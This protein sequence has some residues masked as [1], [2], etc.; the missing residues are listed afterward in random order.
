MVTAFHNNR[1]IF[2]A[3]KLGLAGLVTNLIG[4]YLLNDFKIYS[5][6]IFCFLSLLVLSPTA[7][8]ICSIITL[9][10]SSFFDSSSFDSIRLVLV[11]TAISHLK[12]YTPSVSIPFQYLGFSILTAPLS[13]LIVQ[14]NW[15]EIFLSNAGETILLLISS[16]L[17]INNKLYCLIT[18]RSPVNRLK[19]LFVNCASITVLVGYFITIFALSY[20]SLFASVNT[21]ILILCPL[22]ICGIIP[23]ILHY[24]A[25]WLEKNYGNIERKNL[26]TLS[27]TNYKFSDSLNN[28]ENFRNSWSGKVPK[29]LPHQ[30]QNLG[31]IA[32]ASN[33]TISFINRQ[34]R[35]LLQIKNDELIGQNI[36]E[37]ALAPTITETIKSHLADKT[38]QKITEIKLGELSTQIIYL[39]INSSQAKDSAYASLSGDLGG[40]II[41]IKDISMKRS[42]EKE[43]LQGQKI[44]SIGTNLQGLAHSLNNHL[45]SIVGHLSNTKL[46]EINPEAEKALDSALIASQ[47]AANLIKQL[48]EY[49][50]NK[51]L[52]L[53]T[54]NLNNLLLNKSSIINNALGPRGDLVWNLGNEELSIDC[55]QNLVLQAIVNLVKNSK[56]AYSGNNIQRVTLSLSSENLI[57]EMAAMIPGARAGNYAVLTVQDNATGMTSDILRKAFEPMFGTKKE[58]GQ[59]G[60]GLSI[61]YS[62][63][64]AHDG[65]MSIES[66]PNK[67]TSVALYFPISKVASKDTELQNRKSNLNQTN[68]TGKQI[69]IVEDDQQVLAVVSKMLASL[70]YSVSSCSS[71]QAALELCESKKFDLI[72]SDLMMPN[73][74]GLEFMKNLNSLDKKTKVLL[75]TGCANSELENSDTPIIAKPFDM[76]TLANAV[77]NAMVN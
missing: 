64:R 45:T 59:P 15:G 33:N 21:S 24:P 8:L 16:S 48:L 28:A 69:L 61:V 63:V 7:T 74:S 13:N 53:E 47:Q 35:Q 52:K 50:E 67:G 62:I 3:I 23:Q 39:E 58:I 38:K 68:L 66:T 56:E 27:S 5:G 43:L 18:N 55:D 17:L 6:L 12:N 57:E 40:T 11:L 22:L 10:P 37:L 36:V 71:A 44:L 14:K 34:A 72:L 25:I 42:L 60:L 54:R 75:M 49:T 1:E 46:I 31:I 32:L 2:V 30:D 73:M 51:P 41:T 26:K 76:E 9:I 19:E 20:Q 29:G 4:F 70:G 77:Q 65:F